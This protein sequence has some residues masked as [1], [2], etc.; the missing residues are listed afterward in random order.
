MKELDQEVSCKA[1]E[2]NGSICHD[3]M[4]YCKTDLVHPLMYSSDRYVVGDRFHDGKKS[5]HKK[6]TCKYQLF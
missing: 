5:G 6:E 3:H 2:F 4:Y 1:F